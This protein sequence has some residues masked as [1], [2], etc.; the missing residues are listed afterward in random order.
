MRRP[1]DA[2]RIRRLMRELGHEA[3]ADVRLYFTGGATAVLFGWRSSTVDVDVK[4]EP[5]S[6]RLLR[7]AEAGRSTTPLSS[8]A[9]CR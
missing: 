4:L 6:D 5:D 9:H 2:E 1:V 8:T 7:K 3:E